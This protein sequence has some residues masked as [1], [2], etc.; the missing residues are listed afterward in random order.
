M[1][2]SEMPAASVKDTVAAMPILDVHEHH[3]PETYLSREVG[4][5]DLL[6]QSYAG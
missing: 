4:L 5:L 2:P 1:E 6:R 3:L